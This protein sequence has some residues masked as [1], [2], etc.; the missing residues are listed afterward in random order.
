MVD[1]EYKQHHVPSQHQGQDDLCGRLIYK[2]I[3]VYLSH[4][5]FMF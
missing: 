2:D 3:K 1:Y 5:L 4:S